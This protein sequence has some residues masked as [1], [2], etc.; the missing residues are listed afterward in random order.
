MI[1]TIPKYTKG[2]N[3]YL[4][5]QYITHSIFRVNPQI[6]KQQTGITQRFR[7]SHTDNVLGNYQTCSGIASEIVFCETTRHVQ[8]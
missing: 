1:I 6:F 8:V 4:I 2:Y 5:G 7:F 3:G